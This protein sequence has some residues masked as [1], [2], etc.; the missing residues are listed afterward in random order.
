MN[1]TLIVLITCVFVLVVEA[2]KLEVCIHKQNYMTPIQ[3][4]VS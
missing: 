3:N 2:Q 1:K 4:M